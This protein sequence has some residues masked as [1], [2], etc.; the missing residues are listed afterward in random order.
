MS[1]NKLYNANL[2]NFAAKCR[3][4]IYEKN[5]P[6]DIVPIPGGDLKSPEYLALYPLGLTP[7]FDLGG[8]VIGESEV[9]LEYLEEKFPQPPLLPRDPESRAWVRF[10]DRFHDLHLEPPLRSLYPQLSL[11]ERDQALI[12][13]KLGVVYERLD[14]LEGWSADGP[15]LAG[16]EFTFADCAF[17]PTGFFLEG[18]LPG[19]GGRSWLEGHPKLSAWWSNVQ[20]RPTVAKVLGEQ[21]VALQERM[22]G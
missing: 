11:R 15:F 1:T 2:S 9:I 13:E 12:D 18:F 7:G 19:L 22:G 6:V 17:A 5:A 21:R 3:I 14:L 16:N 8:R 10:L 4:A 20:Q